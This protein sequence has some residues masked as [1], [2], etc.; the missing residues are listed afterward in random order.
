MKNHKY[1]IGDSVIIKSLEW[2]KKNCDVNGDI[3]VNCSFVEPMSEFCGI[4]MTII[5]YTKDGYMMY[6]NDWEWSDDMFETIKEVRK[7]KLKKL[8]CLKN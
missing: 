8:K 5:R 7:R 6:D 3:E 2:Y 4:K 1:K